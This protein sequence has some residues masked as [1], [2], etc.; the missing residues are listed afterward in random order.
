[1]KKTIGV[2]KLKNWCKNKKFDVEKKIGVKNQ[3]FGF[4]KME[5]FYT[6]FDS[7]DEGIFFPPKIVHFYTFFVI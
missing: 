6:N 2:K 3:K 7:R 1:V 4:K 5:K